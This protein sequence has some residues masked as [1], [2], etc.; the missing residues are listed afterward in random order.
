M[1]ISQSLLHPAPRVLIIGQVLTGVA[2]ILRQARQFQ[3]GADLRL[4][5]LL[6]ILTVDSIQVMRTLLGYGLDRLE[7]FIY[8]S[9]LFSEI[10]GIC[11][12]WIELVALRVVDKS[13]L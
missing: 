12:I 1:L 9:L 2:H 7:T 10:V 5:L 11:C 3:D 13:R 4:R 6:V 8:V